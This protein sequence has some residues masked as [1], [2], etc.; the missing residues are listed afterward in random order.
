M[1]YI[2]FAQFWWN[3]SSRSQEWMVWA[4]TSVVFSFLDGTVATATKMVTSVL[5]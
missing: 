2:Y 5:L 3:R 4:W 1:A